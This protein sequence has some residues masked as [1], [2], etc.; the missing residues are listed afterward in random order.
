V[1]WSVTAFLG[2]SAL[3]LFRVSL[4]TAF[5]SQLAGSAPGLGTPEDPAERLPGQ[6]L[7]A[8]EQSIAALNDPN[9]YEISELAYAGDPDF[10]LFLHIRR[11][12]GFPQT[13]TLVTHRATGYLLMAMLVSPSDF[14]KNVIT[15]VLVDQGFLE[16]SIPSGNLVRW[17]GE[18][19]G[20]AFYEAYRRAI[21]SRSR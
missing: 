20:V 15:V 16:R 14:A 13:A 9:V 1:G 8:P 7:S 5:A 19:A 4:A 17:R 18:N 2:A 3:A 10:P 21:K 6:S 11:S 12:V